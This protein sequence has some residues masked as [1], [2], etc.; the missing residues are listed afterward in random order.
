MSGGCAY[1]LALACDLREFYL[2]CSIVE[3]ALK[4]LVL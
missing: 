1:S 3:S 2:K 4:I